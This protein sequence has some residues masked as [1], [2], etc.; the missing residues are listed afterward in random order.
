MTNILLVEDDPLVAMTLGSLIELE[1]GYRVVAIADSLSTTHE[2]LAQHRVELALVDIQLA[3][4]STGYSVAGELTKLGIPCIFV[5]G[6]VPPFP[7]PEF[8]IGCIAKPFSAAAIAEALHI[9]TMPRGHGPA[10]VAVSGGFQR[11]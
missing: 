6:N 11:Y 3:R 8:A 9:A 2:A 5:T 7:M 1:L 10:L 4:L